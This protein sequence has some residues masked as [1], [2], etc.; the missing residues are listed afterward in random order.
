MSPDLYWLKRLW[1]CIVA[2]HLFE[3]AAEAASKKPKTQGPV[4]V[5]RFKKAETTDDKL[6]LM[7]ATMVGNQTETTQRFEKVDERFNTVDKRI[8]VLEKKMADV[9]NKPK[10]QALP[11]T[12]SKTFKG[13]L[14]LPFNCR[15]TVAIGVF[16]PYT[17]ADEMEAATST[18]HEKFKDQ[19]VHKDFPR[20]AGGVVC[21]MKFDTPDNMW[22]A[23]EWY[24]YLSGEDK[25]KGPDGKELWVSVDKRKEERDINS[26]I[27]IM[28]ETLQQADPTEQFKPQY[29]ASKVVRVTP[30]KTRGP[31]CTLRL[32]DDGVNWEELGVKEIPEPNRKIIEDKFVE[33]L[34]LARQL[35]QGRG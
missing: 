28:I 33:N 30:G 3:M 12:A 29:P 16:P 14:T 9:E 27:R 19:I 6:L 5:D 7:F 1:M 31:L 22:A 15:S 32:E 35:R 11:A 17:Q 20:G 2:V 18:F 34:I 26:K 23:I 24:K 4:L 13:D 21:K 25:M 8:D 10:V